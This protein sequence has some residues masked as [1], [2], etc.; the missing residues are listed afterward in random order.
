MFRFRLTHKLILIIFALIC[1]A[2][3]GASLIYQRANDFEKATL[4]IIDN[5]YP[6]QL[7]MAEAKVIAGRISRETAPIGGV[8]AQALAE[9]QKDFLDQSKNFREILNRASGDGAGHPDDLQDVVQ[10]FDRVESFMMSR[11]AFDEPDADEQSRQQKTFESLRSNLED[12]LNRLIDEIG[13]DTANIIQEAVA[14]KAHGV[15][16]ATITMAIGSALIFLFVTIWMSFRVVKPLGILTGAMLDL[17][18]Q[19]IPLAMSDQ[20]RTDELGDLAR[21]VRKFREQAMAVK[22]LE[23]QQESAKKEAEHQRAVMIDQVSQQFQADVLR[24]IEAVSKA[25]KQLFESAKIMNE[26]TVEADRQT[27]L[28]LAH[29]DDTRQVVGTIS[30]EVEL[31]SRSVG[32]LR[33]ALANA[34]RLSSSSARDGTH[35]AERAQHLVEA[36][37]NIGKVA[38]FI[39]EV[40]HQTNLLALNATIE[41]ARSGAAG[42]GFAVVAQE[43]KRLAAQ[44]AEA[45]DEIKSC[46]DEVQAATEGVVDAIQVAVGSSTAIAEMSDT[47]ALSADQRDN[48]VHAVA[49]MV[50]SSEEHTSALEQSLRHIEK[51]SSEAERTSQF[52]LEAASELSDQAKRLSESSRVFLKEIRA[53]AA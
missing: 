6:T 14:T 19:D 11:V 48:A 15:A 24:I 8:N 2:F 43:V 31:L 36:V 20:T 44:S 34:A 4:D 18:S 33:S 39:S 51:G 49:E 10:K 12:S 45:A 53:R 30:G 40:S 29:S 21:A 17:S 25:A 9:A 5:R 27:S 35:A 3:A 38:V 13:S 46:I 37:R 1:V 47:I 32:D 7:L 42:V 22:W 52:I 41:A 16:S 50:R 28:V 26:L 23:E